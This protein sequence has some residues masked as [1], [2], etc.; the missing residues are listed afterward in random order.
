ML[1]LSKRTV[2]LLVIASVVVSG[3]LVGCAGYPKAVTDA[4]AAIEAAK[5]AGKDKQ[6]PDEFNAAEKAKA[7][8]YAL[9]SPCDQ[10][11]AIAKANEAIA[12]AKA[13]C[14]AK[15]VAVV[16]A[17]VPPKPAPPAAP[18]PAP[19]PTVSLSASPNSIQKGQCS[20]LTWSSANTTSVTI[21][22]GIGKVD[23]SGSKQVCPDKTTQY[24]IAV[25]GQSGAASGVTTVM[26]NKVIEQISLHI[27]FDFNKSTIKAA[28][29][30]DLQK[31]IAFAKKY[32]GTRITLVGF[33]DS[34]GSDKYNQG[35]SERRAQAVKDY[36]TS[37]GIDGSRIE[38]SGRGKADPV[39]SNDTEK[40]RAEN[41][42]VEI[43]A[44]SD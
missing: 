3:G 22:Q 34:V 17:P 8:A 20:N 10:S 9:C 21:D 35:L 30:A 18:A 29:D 39:A 32:A 13:L 33:T 44:L 2:Q 11:K 15:P 36:L 41:R 43:S 1:D 12:K 23:S 25:V 19:A 4:N 7:E 14:P 28:E 38:A 6:C 24:N 5:A 42:R 26:V 31:A 40:G 16:E 37:H 27:N